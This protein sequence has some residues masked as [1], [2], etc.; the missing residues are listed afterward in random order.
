MLF[1][2]V[3]IQTIVGFILRMRQNRFDENSLVTIFHPPYSHDLS[4]RDFWLFGHIKTSLV[5]R[6]FSNL[7]VFLEAVIEFVNEIQ[8]S[9]LQLAPL[10]RINEMGLSQQWKL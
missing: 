10:D 4:P 8:P 1:D 3:F 9:E 7:D 2:R 6:A 5:G